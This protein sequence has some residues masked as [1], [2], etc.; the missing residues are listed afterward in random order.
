MVKLQGAVFHELNMIMRAYKNLDASL[1]GG[2]G[3][4][5]VCK[6]SLYLPRW[7]HQAGGGTGGVGSILVLGVPPKTSLLR[8]VWMLLA[9]SDGWRA[10]WRAQG[11]LNWC[12]NSSANC[13]FYIFRWTYCWPLHALFVLFSSSADHFLP[14]LHWSFIPCHALEITVLT[15]RIFFPLLTVFLELL[16]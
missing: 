15:S 16:L 13:I 5:S 14:F 4:G 11:V 10:L 9:C 7:Y 6:T 2:G 8:R 3:L 1:E 12:F